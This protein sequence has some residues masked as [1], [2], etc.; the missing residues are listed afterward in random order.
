MIHDNQNSRDFVSPK[1]HTDHNCSYD[2]DTGVDNGNGN[3]S[4]TCEYD[5]NN[6]Y[7]K[8]LLSFEFNYAHFVCQINSR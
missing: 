3:K 7:D 6:E 1:S 8:T 5:K 2:A 4:G